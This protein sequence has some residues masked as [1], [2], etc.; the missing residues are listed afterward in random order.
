V[1]HLKEVPEEGFSLTCEKNRVRRTGR[2]TSPT[3]IYICNNG[4]RGLIVL[5]RI[6]IIMIWHCSAKAMRR[7]DSI[8]DSFENSA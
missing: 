7:S 8:S 3:R 1:M 6:C 5:M 2:E 4:A